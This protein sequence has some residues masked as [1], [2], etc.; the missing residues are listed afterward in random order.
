[1]ASPIGCFPLL[2][3]GSHDTQLQ[4]E[5]CYIQADNALIKLAIYFSARGQKKSE[6]KSGMKDWWEIAYSAVTENG[7]R[8]ELFSF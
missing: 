3:P 5:P 7:K 6:H 1:M 8:K 4:F 2:P